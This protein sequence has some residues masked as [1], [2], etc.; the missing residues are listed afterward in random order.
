MH[1]AVLYRLT[2]LA[3]AVSAGHLDHVIWTMRSAGR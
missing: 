1:S 3:S 2:W